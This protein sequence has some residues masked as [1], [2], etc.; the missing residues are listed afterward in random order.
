MIR[1]NLLLF[2]FNL[3]PIPPL[4]GSKFLIDYLK[5]NPRNGRLIFLMESRGPFYLIMF[6]LIDSFL[7]NSL[8]FGTLFG[9]IS[10]GILRVL[11]F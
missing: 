9:V 5:R 10:G 2:V 7:L 6:L 3:I 1:I 8:I 11:G 4:D